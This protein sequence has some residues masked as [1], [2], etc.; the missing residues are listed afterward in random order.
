MGTEAGGVASRIWRSGENTGTRTMPRIRGTATTWCMVRMRSRTGRRG[1][2]IAPGGGSKTG[3]VTHRLGIG[4]VIETTGSTTEVGAPV[5]IAT[6]MSDGTA[7]ATMI[8][9][10][11]E[12]EI[13][14]EA[15]TTRGEATKPGRNTSD[16]HYIVLD[17]AS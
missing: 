15:M 11:T 16:T 8:E 5:E 4:A 1:I 2:K 17:V 6:P 14:A 10:D 3:G 12:S 13:G 7:T 9:E